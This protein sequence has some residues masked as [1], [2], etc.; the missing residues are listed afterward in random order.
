MTS[1][2]IIWVAFSAN[3]THG[4]KS[5]MISGH[6]DEIGFIV[7]ILMIMDIFISLISVVGGIK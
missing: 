3:A 2:K 1:L 4:S 6:L 5:I 7:T